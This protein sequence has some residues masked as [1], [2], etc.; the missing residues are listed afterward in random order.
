MPKL[1]IDDKPV[2][3]PEGTTITFPNKKKHNAMMRQL[4]E[5]IRVLLFLCLN[6]FG[7]FKTRYAEN[8]T[9]PINMKYQQH[10]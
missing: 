5:E 2:E 10:W 3:V 7:S 4:T 6:Q 9:K 1:T 8:A